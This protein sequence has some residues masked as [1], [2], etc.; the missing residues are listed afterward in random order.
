MSKGVLTDLT[1]CIGCGSCVVACKMWNKLE[2]DT[3]Q[4]AVGPAA[5][6]NDK[7]WTIVSTCETQNSKGEPVWRFVK[8]QCMHCLEPACVSACFSRAL[9]KNPDGSIV[10]YPDLCV[11]CRYCMLACP[12]DVP[13]YEWHKA[14]PE[15]TKCQMCSSRLENGEAPAC[16]S[17][18]PTGVM[19]LDDRDKLVAR[20]EQ[21]IRDNDQY[22]KKI[23]GKDEV[24][25]TSWLYIS[26][27][28][29]EEL[30]FKAVGMTALPTYTQRFLKHTPFIAVGWGVLL[31]ALSFYTRRRNELAKEKQQNRQV[32]DE[33]HE[34]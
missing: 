26:D 11:G 12:F 32:E 15:I 13:K 21:L 34:S 4:P 2:Y 3:K 25:G 7:N 17:V 1:K 30:G 28:S 8:R 6:L 31:A 14:A 9:Q 10:Y 33:H 16:V 24:G 29:F 19:Q 23:Y 18:C 27:I 5:K 22:V 20:A